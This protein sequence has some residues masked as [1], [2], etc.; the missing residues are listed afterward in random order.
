MN[1]DP[2]LGLEEL[3]FSPSMTWTLQQNGRA[4]AEAAL[5]AGPGKGFEATSNWQ[6]NKDEVQSKFQ[7]YG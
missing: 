5:L 4:Q 2:A 1:L 6:K 7:H 3:N